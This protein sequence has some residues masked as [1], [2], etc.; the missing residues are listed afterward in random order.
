MQRQ[1]LPDQRHPRGS[2]CR[3]MPHSCRS[4]S[5]AAVLGRIAAEG[6]PR[7]AIQAD[8]PAPTPAAAQSR[9]FRLRAQAAS[10]AWSARLRKRLRLR[11]LARWRVR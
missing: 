6:A 10:V 2:R 7:A 8:D 9:Y 4:H 5:L 3:T 1:D 11:R